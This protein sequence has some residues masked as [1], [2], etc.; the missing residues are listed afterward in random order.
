MTREYKSET[1]AQ[2][3]EDTRRAIVQALIDVIRD[4][5]VHAFSMQNVADK[6]GVAL[7]TVYRHFD[8]REALLEALADVTQEQMKALGV[9]LPQSADEAVMLLPQQY[10]QFDEMKDALRAS[11]AASIA[12]GHVP[13]QNVK[14]RKATA[15]ALAAE[16][17]SLSA[18]ELQ[19]AAAVIG[20][21]AGSR[22]WY[23]LSA[24][25]GLSA[26]EGGRAATWALRALIE[27][28]KRR[29]RNAHKGERK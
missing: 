28:L 17:P 10:L 25:Y 23:V 13:R 21:I 15:Q 26:T 5:G 1:R 22:G 19:E 12:T 3:K 11:V 4:D 8:S 18:A 9:R 29:D 6:A 16:F 27:D 24:E 20:M 14:M 2:A 7:R